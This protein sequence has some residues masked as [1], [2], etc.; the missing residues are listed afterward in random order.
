MK[1]EILKRFICFAAGLFLI[2]LC[3]FMYDKPVFKYLSFLFPLGLSLILVSPT[4]DDV[5]SSKPDW[6]IR[7]TMDDEGGRP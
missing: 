4:D 6:V 2:A 5:F 7:I 3:G 1:R